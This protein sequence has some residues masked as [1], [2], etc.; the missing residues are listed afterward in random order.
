MWRCAHPG[1][2]RIL[3]KADVESTAPRT[4]TVT[5]TQTC[6]QGSTILLKRIPIAGPSITDREIQYVLEAVKSGWY[7]DANTFQERFEETCAR[8]SLRKFALSL[9][10]C[11]S[12]LHLAV[13]AIGLGPGDEVVVA[14]ATWIASASPVCYVGATPVFADV[15]SGSW[16]MSAAAL[17]AAITPRTKAAIVTDLYGGM[18]DWDAL[19]AVADRRG[20]VLIE[21]AAEA[22]GSLWSGRPAGSFGRISTFSFHGSKTVTTGEGGMILFD[23]AA[24]LE[25]LQRLRNHGLKPGD[26]MF[27]SSEIAFKYKM[28][29]LQ[30]ALGLAQM[31][32][33]DELVAMKRAIFGWYR[34][35][36]GAIGSIQLNPAGPE[37]FNS[38]WMTTAILPEGCGKRRVIEALRRN[39]VDSR[40]F[41]S[42]LSSLAPFID[43][44]EGVRGRQVNHVSARLG[45]TGINLPSAASLTEADVDVAC[46]T[47][48]RI[49]DGTIV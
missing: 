24:L 34:D 47:L 11:T 31:E 3:S 37:V 15:E 6:S 27:D 29:S 8:L 46:Q 13:K 19:Q 35:R 21:D 30:A 7:T 41:F 39:G 32:R 26:V 23:D 5:V 10:S 2:T 18:P 12:G 17:D 49:I 44:A 48:L 28:S 33:L 14:D 20:I 45:A 40:P 36:L 43:T 16:C 22:I 42:P 1:A 4:S 9:P 25:P 38:Y